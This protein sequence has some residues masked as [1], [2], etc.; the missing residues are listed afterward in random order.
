[1]GTV[2]KVTKSPSDGRIR[3]ATIRIQDQNGDTTVVDDVPV[4]HLA[5]L[6]C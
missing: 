5:P 4:Q 1:M 3:K 2:L 6:E